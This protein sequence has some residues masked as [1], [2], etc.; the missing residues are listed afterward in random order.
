MPFSPA[1]QLL[2]L[3]S[4]PA[5]LAV[6]VREVRD[7]V[8]VSAEQRPVSLAEAADVEVRISGAYDERPGERRVADGKLHGD[9]SAVAPA[10]HYW[11]PKSQRFNKRCDVIGD[12]AIGELAVWVGRPPMPAAVRR[13]DPVFSCKQGGN[14]L[15]FRSSAQPTVIMV[16]VLNWRDSSPT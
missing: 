9:L 7:A 5:E 14:R 4:P 2:D 6:Q 3:V 11:T 16:K 1:V 12:A 13:D 15:P 10:A 8:V